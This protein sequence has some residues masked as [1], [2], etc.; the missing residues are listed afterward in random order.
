MKMKAIRI[1]IVALLIFGFVQL[2]RAAEPELVKATLIADTS[3][4]QPGKPFRLGLGL[5]IEP[6]WHLYWKNPG[7]GGIPT[8]VELKLPEGFTS[9]AIQY[10]VPRKLELEGGLLAYGY[11]NEVM[12]LATITPPAQLSKDQSKFEIVAEANWLVCEKS[13]VLG[14]ATVSTSLPV[15][16]PKPVEQEKFARW[17]DR[18][19]K[20]A[21]PAVI[22]KVSWNQKPANE[23]ESMLV[24]DVRWAGQVPP[25]IEW[26]PPASESVLFGK[27]SVKTEDKVTTVSVSVT[28]MEGQK[29]GSGPLESVLSYKSSAGT[30]G[31]ALPVKLGN[32]SH[33]GK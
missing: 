10:P 29:Q 22:D 5:K 14:K 32:E 9:S 11:E 33:A 26:Y 4:I 13:C 21:D 24:L 19:P 17:I 18:M 27:P 16:D 12:L 2:A 8:T 1:G 25:E 31:A 6:H 20:P 3:A 23:N 15:G 28:R 30:V 7:D